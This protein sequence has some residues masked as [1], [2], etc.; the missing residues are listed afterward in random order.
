MA[1]GRTAPVE[2][3]APA[4]VDVTVSL[5][6]G[7]SAA[8]ALFAVS[9][10]TT[11]SSTTAIFPGDQRGG[12]SASVLAEVF[13]SPV[14]V[15]MSAG[16]LSDPEHREK[17]VAEIHRVEES[18]RTA[19]ITRAK[20]LGLPL[21]VERPDGSVIELAGFEGDTPLYLTTHNVNAAISTGANLLRAAPYAV[22]GTGSTVG[23]WDAGP[24]LTTHQEFG[25]RATVK[26]TVVYSISSHAT[27]VSGTLSAAGITASAKGMAPSVRV[28]SYDWDSA[29]SEMTACGATYPGET[30]KISISNHS[31][32]YLSGWAYTTLWEWYGTGTTAAGV[33]T[34]FG[35]YNTNARDTD[36]LSYSMPYFLIVRSAGND[37][38]DNPSAGSTV[39]LSPGGTTTVA[40]DSTL[41]PPGDGSYRGGYDT[42]GYDSTAKNAMV[43]GSVADAVTSGV[44]DPTKAAMQSYSCWGPTDD[45]RIKPDLVANGSGLYSSVSSSTTAY[46][47]MSGTSMS[48]PN[49]AGTAQLIVDYFTTLFPGRAMRA[50]TLRALL[51]HTAS[52]LGTAGPD[53]VYGWGLLNGKGAAD[54]LLS[55]FSHPGTRRVVENRLTASHP[56]YTQTFTWDGGSPIRVTLA[57]TDPAGTST[58][59]GDSRT[60]R[61]VNNLNLVVTGPAGSSHNPF[62]MPFVGDWTTNTLASAAVTGTNTTDNV[63]Q[64]WIAA[65]PAAGVY[66]ITVNYSGTLTNGAQPF[67]LIVSGS[68]NGDVAPAPT[69]SASTPATGTGTVILTLTG[70]NLL[71]GATVTLSMAGQPDVDATGVE[72]QGD[73]ARARVNTAGMAAGL[74]N[75][76]WTNPDG[77]SATLTNA[78]AIISGLWSEDFETDTIASR[79]WTFVTT[80]GVN[81]WVTTTN[82]CVSPTRSMFASGPSSKADFS[83]V[84]PSI[85]I[86]SGATGLRLSFWQ[87]YNFQT[88]RDGG[89]LEFSINGGSWFDVTSTGSGAAFA[90]NS[91]PR[92]LSSSS[93]PLNGRSAWTGNSG[94]WQQVLVDLTNAAKYDGQNLRVRW[95]VGTNTGTA[96]TGWY[97][98]DVMISGATPANLPPAIVTSANAT[99]SPVTATSTALNVGASDDGGESL[100]MYTWSVNDTFD[101]PVSFSENGNNAAKNT[102]AVFTQAGTYQF[103]VNIRDAEGLST[104]S[105]VEVVVGQTLTG[106]NVSPA[107]VVVQ[108]GAT[109]TFTAATADQF[110]HAL[111]SPPVLSWDVSGG[112]TINTGG[113]FT[114]GSVAGGPFT[115]TVASGGVIGT[116][117]VTVDDYDAWVAGYGL[118]GAPSLPDADPDGDGMSNRL[119]KLFGFNPTDP[120]SSLRFSFVAPGEGT[121]RMEINR[122][123]LQ[124]TFRIQGVSDPAG[125]WAD[126]WMVP[127][128]NSATNFPVE[129]PDAAD[130]HHYRLRYEP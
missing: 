65:P 43:I 9:T 91:Y 95:R 86:P 10:N 26:D 6:A 118:T 32:G 25:S 60:P 8:P 107:S 92:T 3:P 77:Q 78:F 40:Y 4:P 87:N 39:T 97:V 72:A 34:D 49:A 47:T 13:E 96:S 76:T 61:L 37:R 89:V 103:T 52:D 122:V 81:Q 18:R 48:S 30:G 111:A 38:S 50:A 125:T 59:T 123:I 2:P 21:R 62:V 41:H 115:V 11:A 36:S 33:E 100:L 58:S 79:G 126:E 24:I 116:A 98:D 69:L 14:D 101:Y 70:G 67:S 84:S 129:L 94:G 88:S 29:S 63:E 120:Q 56:S 19:A 112:G 102:M 12:A 42:L 68:A 15:L 1:S 7:R 53:Y 74:W 73:T 16:D 109:Q 90:A 80:L 51:I 128:T 110:G 66:T 22:D 54:H 104:S 119:E 45:G 124:G 20:G 17:A 85:A 83:L 55:W 35:K 27:H 82:S 114:A 64:V 105:T 71:L 108:T 130:R 113:M 28:D 121:I 127:V 46:G 23:V 99:P 31:Y 57:W 93:S 5:P 106:L 117:Q 44:R 75:V